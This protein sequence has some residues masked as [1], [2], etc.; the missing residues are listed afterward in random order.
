[1][2]RC[3]TG[4]RNVVTVM[5][6]LFCGTNINQLR[7][8]SKTFTKKIVSNK[9]CFDKSVTKI[10]S[11]TFL[12]SKSLEELASKK[13]EMNHNDRDRCVLQYDSNSKRDHII[14]V[15]VFFL[16]CKLGNRREIL[17]I[18]SWYRNG[19]RLL[20]TKCSSSMLDCLHGIRFISINWVVMGH[21]FSSI[22]RDPGINI[23]SFAQEVSNACLVIN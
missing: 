19:K 14:K 8:L 21:S 17:L 16:I 1:M 5:K 22:F 20:S 12:K 3:M 15:F 10:S 9:N 4:W 11:F 2:H 23:L 13:L 7:S 18:F 6:Y